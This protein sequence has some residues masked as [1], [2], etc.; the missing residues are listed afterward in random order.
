VL[1][2]I[3]TGPTND[4]GPRRLGISPR[5]VRKHVEGVFAKAEVPSRTATVARW[6]P[7]PPLVTA[8]RLTSG[9]L[10]APLPV[11]VV[12]GGRVH[13]D[14]ARRGEATVDTHL[15]TLTTSLGHPLPATG[16]TAD[17]AMRL[18]DRFTKGE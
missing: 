11:E 16:L 8:A 1:A 4:Q 18:N 14:D 13:R 5:T 9:V 10:G 3:A 2:L 7:Q 17:L 12:G 15:D 6:L